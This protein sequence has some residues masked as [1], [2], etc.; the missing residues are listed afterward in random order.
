MISTQVLKFAGDG[1]ETPGSFA[2]G[3]QGSLKSSNLKT[4]VIILATAGLYYMLARLGLALQFE[5]TQA[6][7][8]WA[9]SGFAIAAMLVLGGRAIPGVL[10][11]AFAANGEPDGRRKQARNR[12]RLHSC[13]RHFEHAD[14]VQR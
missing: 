1:I 8:V 9:P 13:T 12:N 4:V 5:Q 11:G 6:S 10:I 3:L 14:G 7:P 2:N